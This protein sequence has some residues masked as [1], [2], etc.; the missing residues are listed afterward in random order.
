[1][2]IPITAS[3]PSKYVRDA[4]FLNLLSATLASA[5]TRN[6][7]MLTWRVHRVNSLS[8][9]HR[10]PSS[11]IGR[12]SKMVPAT[13]TFKGT[14]SRFGAGGLWHAHALVIGAKGLNWRLTADLW[15]ARNGIARVTPVYDG[16][17][18]V[19]A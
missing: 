2:N 1:M 12:R 11:W 5:K 18:A 10:D 14:V 8:R 3:I 13:G 4:I 16:C 17:G 9:R 15:Q 6:E 19:W 7:K